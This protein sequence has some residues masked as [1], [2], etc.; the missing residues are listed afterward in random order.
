MT[1]SFFSHSNKKKLEL[2]KHEENME[3][4]SVIMPKDVRWLTYF[5]SKNRLIEIY[6]CVIET[7]KEYINDN[8]IVS[9]LVDYY[10][11]YNNM[12]L[13]TAITDILFHINE[14]V[15]YLQKK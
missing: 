8:A 13:L 1:C 5:S 2:I 4:L 11:N 15:L 12:C 7:L 9:F 6:D 10:Q 3:N 14:L